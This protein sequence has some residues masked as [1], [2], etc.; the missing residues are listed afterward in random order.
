M[1]YDVYD[2]LTNESTQGSRVA[3]FLPGALS[4]ICNGAQER[5]L[6]NANVG[7]AMVTWI[8][9]IVAPYAR[10][11]EKPRAITEIAAPDVQTLFEGSIR[12]GEKDA[13]R[14]HG[15]FS[16]LPPSSRSTA[17]ECIRTP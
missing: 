11:R 5:G 17:R 16:R 8:D 9:S 14:G 13:G 12:L 4:A 10:C 3:S 15:A 2:P 1:Q 6:E 7:P